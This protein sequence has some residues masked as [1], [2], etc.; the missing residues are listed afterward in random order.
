MRT[1]LFTIV[2]IGSAAICA[3]AST[4]I[5]SITVDADG[6]A[7]SGLTPGSSA[8][9]FS[10]K[11]VQKGYL[12]GHSRSDNILRPADALGNA[13]LKVRSLPSI[14][15]WCVVDMA[16]GNYAIL[17]PPTS[18]L[19]QTHLPLNALLGSAGGPLNRLQTKHEFVEILWVRPGVGAW[20]LSAG[21]GGARDADGAPDGHVS[22]APEQMEALGTF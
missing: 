14:A 9:I 8:I 19:R 5:P 21:D 13:H 11:S 1:F 16:T 2:M 12:R 10:V 22:V 7:V 3:A 4:T 17:A 15:I 18:A 6:I 20:S